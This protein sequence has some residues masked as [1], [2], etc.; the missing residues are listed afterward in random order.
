MSE[1]QKTYLTLLLFFLFS[2]ID[3]LS[4]RAQNAP[5]ILP[6]KFALPSN[7]IELTR[8]EDCLKTVKFLLWL[9][10]NSVIMTSV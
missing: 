3:H 10:T 4:A 1:K 5:P 7:P 6:A 2:S 9:I 8:T